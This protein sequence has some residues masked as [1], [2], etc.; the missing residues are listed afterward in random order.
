MLHCGSTRSLAIFFFKFE[1]E[2]ITITLSNSNLKDFQTLFTDLT[3]FGERLKGHKGENV[4]NMMRLIL[5]N[6]NF[7]SYNETFRAD[8][9]SDFYKLSSNYF[10]KILK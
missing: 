1:T 6:C 10:L 3:F 4:M 8:C 9:V 2:F 7:F 5:K